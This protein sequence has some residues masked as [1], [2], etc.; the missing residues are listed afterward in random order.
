MPNTLLGFIPLGADDSAMPL[1]NVASVSTSTKFSVTR[2][3]FG[4]LLFLLG[5]AIGDFW[6]VLCLVGLSMM[7]N[8]F[9]SAL[10]IQ[11]NGG[12]RNE[13]H[14]SALGGSKIQWMK[15]AINERLFAD[16]GRLRHEESMHVH[17]QQLQ[18]QQHS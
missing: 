18:A 3:A 9:S 1:A 8:S 5:L 12:G 13:I 11:N 2:A 15:D 10:V 16:H 4:T 17:N 14:V 7:A 6:Y